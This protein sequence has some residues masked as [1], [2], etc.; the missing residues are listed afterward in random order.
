MH[1]RVNFIPI[2]GP[3]NAVGAVFFL[4]VRKKVFSILFFKAF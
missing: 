4:G 1:Q 2:G 3:V